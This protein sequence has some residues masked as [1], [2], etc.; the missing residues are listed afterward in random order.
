MEPLLSARDIKQRTSLS[1]S[2]AYDLIRDF[3]VAGGKLLRIGGKN[4]RVPAKE[5]WAWFN[6]KKI[7]E[8]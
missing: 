6:A 5:F 1:M 7:E 3:R 8:L 4:L 2:G